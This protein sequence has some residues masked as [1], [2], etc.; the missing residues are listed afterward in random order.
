M[1]S[2]PLPVSTR[3]LE[4]QVTFPD[5][6]APARS[7]IYTRN[8]LWIAAPPERIW[9]WLVDAAR[10]PAYYGNAKNIVLDDGA[11]E[12]A[13]GT[14]FHWTTF[15]VRVHTVVEEL[16]RHRR[17]S[18][19]GKG[20]GSTEYHG[21]VLVPERGGTRVI[22]EETQQGFVASLGRAF[23]RRGLLTWHQRWLEGL[24]AQA[25]R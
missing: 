24:A 7:P 17:L 20:L 3:S 1:T 12:L 14:R 25:A 5:A 9:P 2:S 4:P 11:V 15:G 19:S 10:W 21:W 8:E 13:L 22:T 16:Q 18:W 6:Q 23:L